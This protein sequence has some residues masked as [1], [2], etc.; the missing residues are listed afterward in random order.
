MKLN[1]FR[2]IIRMLILENNSKVGYK[3]I[4]LAGL[5]GGG[6]STL[7]K[8]ISRVTSPTEGNLKIYGSVRSL[9]EVGVGFHP[10][11]TG[12]ENIY[13]SGSISGEKKK[14]WLSKF[15]IYEDLLENED[16]VVHQHHGFSLLELTNR[17]S[18]LKK[19][20]NKK[21]PF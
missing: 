17:Q 3:M 13:L 20:K 9:L 4:F 18:F 1:E 7:L 15:N 12:L 10:E 5:P 16:A 14:N 8:I 11:L 19:M 21:I 6:K 2:S